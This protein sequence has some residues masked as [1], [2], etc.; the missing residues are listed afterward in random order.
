MFIKIKPGSCDIKSSNHY[1]GYN[2]VSTREGKLIYAKGEP[3]LYQDNTSQGTATDEVISNPENAKLAAIIEEL[4]KCDDIN[5]WGDLLTG[6]FLLV[7]VNQK[8]STCHII[9]DLGNAYHL[10][11]NNLSDNEIVL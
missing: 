8:T 4:L 5:K 6:A 11:S 7:I 3:R 2:T 1:L 10:F 9:V